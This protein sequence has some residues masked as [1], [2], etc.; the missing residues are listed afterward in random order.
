MLSGLHF[1]IA[2]HIGD[3]SRENADFGLFADTL[4]AR[5]IGRNLKIPYNIKIDI[6][7]GEEHLIDEKT[8]EYT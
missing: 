5:L 8:L 2:E 4:A 3:K 1:K 6:H 7:E